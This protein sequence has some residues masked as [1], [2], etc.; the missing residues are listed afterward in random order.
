M[1]WLQMHQHDITQRQM[2]CVN[3]SIDYKANDALGVGP[4]NSSKSCY[5]PP[6]CGEGTQPGSIETHKFCRWLVGADGAFLSRLAAS[7]RWN[8]GKEQRSSHHDLPHTSHLSPTPSGKQNKEKIFQNG[9]SCKFQAFFCV[10]SEWAF[11]KRHE[12][13]FFLMFSSNSKMRG[14]NSSVQI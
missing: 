3:A 6:A 9:L 5:Q 11:R 7:A 4:G 1:S 14:Y 12:F 8:S 10:G 13:F 2:K